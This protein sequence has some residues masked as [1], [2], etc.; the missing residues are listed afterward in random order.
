MHLSHSLSA[1]LLTHISQCI[2]KM[3][4]FKHT[5]VGEGMHVTE[6]N[7]GDEAFIQAA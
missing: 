3:L 2:G 5:A 4:G 6:I 7:T 1:Q